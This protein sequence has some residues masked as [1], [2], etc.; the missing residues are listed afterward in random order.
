MLC[1]EGAA[2]PHQ[3]LARKGGYRAWRAYSLIELLVVVALL[4]IFVAM[5]MPSFVSALESNRR[6]TIMNRL[7]EDLAMARLQAVSIASP[8]TLCSSDSASAITYSCANSSD[9]SNGWYVYAG[10]AI[11]VAPASIA[12]TAVL[13]TPQPLPNGW[14]ADA[15]LS[16]PSTYLSIDARSSTT[17]IGH[18]T[19]YRSGYSTTAGCVT[20]SSTGRARSSTASVTSGLVSPTN[21]PC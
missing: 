19:I 15:S 8:M 17:K 16:N 10:S 12:T 11:V 1:L 14:E 20:V 18:F 4:G 3:F 13:R 9:W 7:M 6:N 2:V 5:A 21:D